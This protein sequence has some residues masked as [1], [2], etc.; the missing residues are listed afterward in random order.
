MIVDEKDVPIN[1]DEKFEA[2]SLAKMDIPKEFSEVSSKCEGIEILAESLIVDSPMK[3][4][5][6]ASMLSEIKE[7]RKS[8]EACIKPSKQQA[9]KIHS[10]YCNLE[11][12]YI[13]PLDHAE[14]LLKHKMVMWANETQISEEASQDNSPSIIPTTD[15]VS[16]RPVWKFEI[17]DEAKVPR[18]YLKV[19][20][21]MLNG[22]AKSTKGAI[23]IDGVRF[24]K[25]NTIVNG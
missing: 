3:Y 1:I 15:N 9:K 12:K 23:E 19:D 6:G 17:L 16:I 11:S 20:T 13:A 18:E 10:N 2:M 25:A 5:A 24:Y 14:E 7:T 8:I 22:L 21:T 4:S